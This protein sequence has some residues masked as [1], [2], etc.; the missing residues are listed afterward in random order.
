MGYGLSTTVNGAKVYAAAQR[1]IA[2]PPGAR[3]SRSRED[4][5]QT[6]RVP[7]EKNSARTTITSHPRIAISLSR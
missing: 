3:K 4:S 1:A 7:A 5:A 6:I 2:A